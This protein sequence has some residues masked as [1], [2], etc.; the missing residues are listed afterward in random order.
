[1]CASY[2]IFWFSKGPKK[3]KIAIKQFLKKS[4]VDMQDQSGAGQM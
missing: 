2:V 4:E 1:M 3:E